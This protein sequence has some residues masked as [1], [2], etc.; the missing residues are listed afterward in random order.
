MYL[1]YQ[2]QKQSMEKSGPWEKGRLITAEFM[3]MIVLVYIQ[4]I[5]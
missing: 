3:I 4:M 2:K 5:I 1:K